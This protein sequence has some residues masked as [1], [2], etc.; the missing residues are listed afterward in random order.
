MTFVKQTVAA[1]AIVAAMLCGAALHSPPAQAAFIMTV[2]EI[3]SD[4]DMFGSGSINL[5]A[6]TSVGSSSTAGAII[7]VFAIIVAGSG[8]ATVY[9]GLS[10]PTSFGSG[11]GADPASSTTGPALSIGD[12]ALDLFVPSGYVS[13]TAISNSMT[14]TGQTLASLG[15]TPGTYIWTWGEGDTADSLTLDV[16]PEPATT[17]LL[18]LPVAATMLAR[19]RSRTTAK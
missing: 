9:E 12:A 3:G 2:E 1:T 15:G 17:L 8:G 4:V 14:F 5:A 16:I 10:G 7:P 11:V 13:G 6:L 18:G 19:R